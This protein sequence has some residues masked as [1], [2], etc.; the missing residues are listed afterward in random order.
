MAS[1]HTTHHSRLSTLTRKNGENGHATLTNRL[2][3]AEYDVLR[4]NGTSGQGSDKISGPFEGN[5][6]SYILY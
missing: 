6:G 4:G 3:R 5:S 2:S 1:D